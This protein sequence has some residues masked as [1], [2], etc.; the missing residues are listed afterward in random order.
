MTPLHTYLPQDRYHALARGESLPERSRGAVLFVDISGF[1]QFTEQLTKTLGTRR[2]AEETRVRLDQLFKHLILKAHKFQGSVISFAGDAM[3]VWFDTD[4]GLRALTAACEMCTS[5]EDLA[6]TSP[7]ELPMPRFIIGTGT[8]RRFIVGDPAIQRLDVLAGE[9]V[10]RASMGG[11]VARAGE[12]VMHSFLFSSVDQKVDV[13]EW[14]TAENGERYAV[15]GNRCPPTTEITWIE[16]MA[17]F[18]DAGLDS[19]LLPT[20]RQ[21]AGAVTLHSEFRPVTALFLRFMGLDYEHDVDAPHKLDTFIRAVQNITAQYEGVLL[22]LVVG[23]KGNFLYVVFGAPITHED[24]VRRAI[25]AAQALHLLPATLGFIPP[26]QI[27]LS[28]GTAFTGV[29]GSDLRRVYSAMGHEVNIAC[30][31]MEAAQAGEILVSQRIQTATATQ[32]TFHARP[33]LKIKGKAEPLSVFTLT[34]KRQPRPIRLQ[35]PDYTLPM[36]G[37]TKELEIINNKLAL[38]SQ[39]KGQVI[40]IEAEAGLGKSRLVAE[41]IHSALKRGFAGY[42]GTS[43]SNEINT[44]YLI[45]KPV[46]QAFFDV[47][48]LTALDPQVRKLEDRLREKVPK[49]IQAMPLLSVLLDLEIPDNH[50]TKN[51][52]PKYRQSALH[53]LLT[54]C[55]K[56]TSLDKPVLIVLEDLHWLDALSHNLLEELSKTLAHYPVCFVL[57]YRPPQMERLQAPRIEALPHFTRLVLPELNQTEI[58]SVIRAKLA[59]LFPARSGAVPVEFVEKLTHWVQGNPF[60]LE[61]ILNSL[62]DHG[63]DPRNPTELEKVELPDSLHT[64]ILSRFERLSARERNTLFAASIIG[65]LFRTRWLTGYYPELGTPPEVKGHLDHLAEMNITLPES[66]EAEPVYLFRHVVTHEVTYESLPFATRAKLHEQLAQYL[67]KAGAPVD[68]IAHHYAHSENTIKQ[69]EYFRKAGDAAQAAY[70]NDTAL[71]YYGRLLA[72]ASDPDGQ[73]EIHMKRGTVL[74]LVGKWAEA[75]N[76]YRAALA[77]ADANAEAQAEV[78]YVL[79]R[80]YRQRDDYASALAWLAQA[81][82]NRA[83][84]N[85]QTGLAQVLIETGFVFLR[86][87]KHKEAQDQLQEGL[88][89]AQAINDP[90]STALALN[91]LGNV[92]FSKSDYVAA[93]ARYEESLVIRRALGNKQNIAIS[94]YNLGLAAYGGHDFATAQAMWEESLTLL[95]EIGYKWGVAGALGNMG[96]VFYYQGDYAEAR[97]RYEESLTLFREMGV[98]WGIANALSNLGMISLEWK[99]YQ[100]AETLH[101]ESLRVRIEIEDKQAVPY[102]LIGLANTALEWQDKEEGGRHAARLAASAQAMMISSGAVVEW[103]F[104]RIYERAVA[105]AREQL[106]EAAFQAAWEEGSQ[107]SLEEAVKRALEKEI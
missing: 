101:T 40:G 8:V 7:V 16:D 56:A 25:G 24:D 28:T 48:P 22:D 50:F 21:T 97:L 44:P 87:G 2:G 59:Q 71:E 4:E 53:A 31:L 30:R 12:I 18:D 90:S 76:D 73:I 17:L 82:A 83:A 100:D 105:A 15:L 65:R 57:A 99:H 14:R 79:G 29:R 36:V 86:Q 75:E 11:T 63:L 103:Y 37:R 72:L 85:D 95:R 96:L 60:Y 39:G 107:W 45:W 1:T 77:L 3:T 92:V 10:E 34:G 91:D 33:L 42:G 94:L 106:G 55:L 35:E 67:E 52:E 80:L 43:Q 88:Q 49:R 68:T 66:S 19:F 102:N 20:L 104:P 69:R 98:K 6:H 27:G 54:D 13:L 74:E 46:W 38:A 26:V 5:V 62:Y 93:R 70:A 84:L 23:D 58:E 32:F 78:Q 9:A 41:V 47:T 51:L 81:Q 64:L 89:L 61:E